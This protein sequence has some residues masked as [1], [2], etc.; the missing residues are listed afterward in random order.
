MLVRL[1]VRLHF[2]SSSDLSAPRLDLEALIIIVLGLTL[3]AILKLRYHR[4]V[5]GPLG[6]LIPGKI[7][8]V[9]SILGGVAAALVI[10]YFTHK[11]GLTMPSVPA[12]DFFVLGFLLGPALEESVFRGYVLPVL[13]RALGRCLSVLVVAL[14][15]AAFH[16]PGD[17]EHWLWFTATGLTYGTLRLASRTTTAPTIL[18]ITCNL[19]LFFVSRIL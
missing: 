9:I 13:T 19:T 11:Q 17:F 5:I 10:T 6:W 4:P 15:F 12:K 8:I 1:A 2:L 16:A 3:Y 18:H 7:Y 14:L